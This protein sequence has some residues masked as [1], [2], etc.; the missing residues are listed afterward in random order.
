[1]LSLGDV[2]SQ[3]GILEGALIKRPKGYS[4]MIE[5]LSSM[6]KFLG[7]SQHWGWGTQA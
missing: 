6:P 7:P 1:M 2:G 3:S 5:F 4:S